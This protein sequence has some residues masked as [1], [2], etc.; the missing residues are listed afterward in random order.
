MNR[1]DALEAAAKKATPEAVCNWDPM[2]RPHYR[3][4]KGHLRDM[5]IKGPLADFIALADPATVLALIEVY[6]AAVDVDNAERIENVH[7]HVVWLLNLRAALS[8]VRALSTE[9]ETSRE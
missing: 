1:I 9:E 4:E 7:L 6:R 5:G 2:E 8:K 3:W